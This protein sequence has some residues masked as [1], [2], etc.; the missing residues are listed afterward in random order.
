[1]TQESTPI[2]VVLYERSERSNQLNVMFIKTKITIGIKGYVEQY[3][4]VQDFLKAIDEQF[5]TLDKALASTLILKFSSIHI[6]S[7]RVCMSTSCKCSDIAAQFKKL[8]IDMLESFL[9]HFILN[10]LYHQHGPF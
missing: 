8:G 2:V 9:V 4:K 6:I 5:F 3:E 7:A 10:T 1:M